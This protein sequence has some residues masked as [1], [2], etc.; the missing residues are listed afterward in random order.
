MALRLDDLQLAGLRLWQDPEAFCFGLDAVLLAH[1]AVVKPKDAVCDLGCGNG[2]VPLLL[3]GRYHPAHV[4]GIEL[5]P[6]AA[7]LARRNVEENGLTASVRILEGDFR[8]CRTLLS[9]NCFAVVTA[10]PPYQ[11]VDSGPERCSL[12]VAIARR[13]RCCV[14][15]DVV[16]AA[17]Y[18]LKPNGHFYVVYPPE[19]LAELFAGMREAG[20]EPKRLLLVQ[21][22]TGRAPSLALVEGRK[23]A[24]SGLRVLPPLVLY[25]PGG[26]PTARLKAVYEGGNLR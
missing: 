15:G 13:E 11:L 25:R 16:S 10:N 7:A 19:R 3:W 23:G 26:K 18:L 22:R 1:F 14:L 9:G 8:N 12:A 20:L 21:P 24:K 5:Q 6:E 2:I 4:T 17:A